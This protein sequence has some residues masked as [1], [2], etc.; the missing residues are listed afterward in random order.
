MVSPEP[1][2][3][4][5]KRNHMQKRVVASG[6]VRCGIC[7]C[8]LRS[9]SSSPNYGNSFLALGSPSPPMVWSG[10]HQSLSCGVSVLSRV[11]FVLCPA[12]GKRAPTPVPPTIHRTRSCTADRCASLCRSTRRCKGDRRSG[13]TWVARRLRGVGAA[14]GLCTFETKTLKGC[15]YLFE[16]KTLKGCMYFPRS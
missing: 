3:A 2:H 9:P 15:M 7:I 14:G 4:P 10:V 13:G 11:A 8:V 12:C 1:T 6:S 5:R 16:T